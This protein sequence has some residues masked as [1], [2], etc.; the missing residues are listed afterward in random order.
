MY[1]LLKT[2]MVP[3]IYFTKYFFFQNESFISPTQLIVFPLFTLFACSLVVQ[4]HLDGSV[5][6]TKSATSAT[7]STEILLSESDYNEL[8][9]SIRRVVSMDMEI[10]INRIPVTLQW[11]RDIR[12]RKFRKYV[13]HKTSS[14]YWCCCFSWQFLQQNTC[15]S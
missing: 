12:R 15:C 7:A 3:K 1:Y 13:K 4:S 14:F 6:S 9:W 8:C 10:N 2:A 5:V 11:T